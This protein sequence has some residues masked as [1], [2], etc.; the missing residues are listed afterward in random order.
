MIGFLQQSEHNELKKQLDEDK[1]IFAL[2]TND[3]YEPNMVISE[4]I[5]WKE[6]AIKLSL[7]H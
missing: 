3:E 5:E 7:F 2:T 4:K 6:A 1:I